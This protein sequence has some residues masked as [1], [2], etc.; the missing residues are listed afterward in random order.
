MIVN[1]LGAVVLLLTVILIHEL[2][3]FTAAKSVGMPVKRFSI[4]FGRK[5][6]GFTWRGTEFQFGWLPLGGF[7]QLETEGDDYAAFIRHP[8]W[9]RLIYFAG[10]VIFNLLFAAALITN[11]HLELRRVMREAPVVVAV[12]QG[13]PCA[14][15]LQVGDQLQQIGGRLLVGTKGLPLAL[16][17]PQ[18]EPGAPTEILVVREGRKVI[19]EV[20][21]GLQRGGPYLGLVAAKK[22]S[23]SVLG[24][25]RRSLEGGVRGT[26]SLFAAT[27]KGIGHLLVGQRSEG[28]KVAGPIQIGAAAYKAMNTGVIALLS[29]G[30]AIS[31]GLAVMNLLPFPGLDGW[32]VG[33]AVFG[34]LRRKDVSEN[35]MRK[36]IRFGYLF[37]FVIGAVVIAADLFQVTKGH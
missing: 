34:M 33:L 14:G 5:V 18:L 26:W 35:F 16:V 3:H 36:T 27:W 8:Q 11:I 7:V 9:K 15:V 25:M 29:I 20:K 12:D 2:G 13:G 6:C 28:T 30:A 21:T 4:G 19:L 24:D 23:G 32:F 31:V 1:I 22:A 10:G 17:T 37:L